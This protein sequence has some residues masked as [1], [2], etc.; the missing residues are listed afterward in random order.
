MGLYTVHVNAAEPKPVSGK[1][2]RVAFP[3]ECVYVKNELVR[4]SIGILKFEI[5]L[6][7]IDDRHLSTFFKVKLFNFG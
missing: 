4:T 3:K 5:V 1:Q 7:Q 2:N 6:G